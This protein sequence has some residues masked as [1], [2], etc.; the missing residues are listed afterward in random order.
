MTH[1]LAHELKAAG[2]PFDPSVSDDLFES[3]KDVRR[4]SLCKVEG[5]FYFVPTLSKLIEA[6]GH[7]LVSLTHQPDG[8]WFAYS[9]TEDEHG[10]NL[11]TCFPTPEEAVAN[12]WLALS[13]QLKN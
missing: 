4:G 13:A 12:L 1:E 10:N 8:R 5:R 3:E 2:F 11:E 9:R 6:C 7:H